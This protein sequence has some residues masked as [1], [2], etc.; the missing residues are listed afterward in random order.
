MLIVPRRRVQLDQNNVLLISGK[1]ANNSTAISDLSY[2]GRAITVYGDTKIT[3]SVA[4]PFGVSEGVLTFDGNGDALQAAYTSLLDLTS[5]YTLEFFFRRTATT[6]SGLF[7]KGGSVANWN[8]ANGI[9]ITAYIFGNVLYVQRYIGGTFDTKSTSPPA[10]NTWTH[11]AVSYDGTTI[12]HF[13]GGTLFGSSTAAPVKP[14]TS[15][16][17]TIGAHVP[18]STGTSFFHAGQMAQF[19]HRLGA[20]YTASFTPPSAPFIP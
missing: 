6:D 3:T 8:T 7:S 19:R 15:N 11:F 1:G 17:Y 2:Y 4:D 10:I 5:P 12:R 13:L 14:A 18:I 9:E 16:I 20:L